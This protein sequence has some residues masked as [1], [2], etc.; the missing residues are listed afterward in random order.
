[1]SKIT[2]TGQLTVSGG[3]LTAKETYVAPAPAAGNELWAWGWNT[4]G[5][6][7]DSTA[8]NKSSP[9]QIGSLTNWADVGITIILFAF[10]FYYKG[11]VIVKQYYISKRS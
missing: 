9:A 10:F 5:Q 7:G 6:L 11:I 1:M 3:Q 2:V 8:T 4:S